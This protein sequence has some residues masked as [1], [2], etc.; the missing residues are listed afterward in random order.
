LEKILNK[1]TFTIRASIEM[2]VTPSMSARVVELDERR[3]E[4]I[5]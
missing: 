4:E 2:G 3:E 5:K 1:L